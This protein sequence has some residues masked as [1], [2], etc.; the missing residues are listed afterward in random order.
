MN[1]FTYPWAHVRFESKRAGVAHHDLITQN[2]EP[3]IHIRH[4]P[5]PLVDCALNLL[6]LLT[7]PEKTTPVA[8]SRTTDEARE[9]LT[10]L[11]RIVPYVYALCTL[12]L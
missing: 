9:A 1:I 7:I 5:C 3:G 12:E 6:S 2:G 10:T 11:I 4:S 8:H